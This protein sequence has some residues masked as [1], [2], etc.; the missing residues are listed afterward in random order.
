MVT[1]YAKLR[2]EFDYRK[3]QIEAIF[4]RESIFYFLE[5]LK[6]FETKCLSSTESKVILRPKGGLQKR[7]NKSKFKAQLT[8]LLRNYTVFKFEN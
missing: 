6:V 4:S 3:L 8:K 7:I 5:V 2:I 1:S